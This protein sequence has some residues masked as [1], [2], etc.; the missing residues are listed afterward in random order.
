MK[1][2]VAAMQS[3]YSRQHSGRSDHEALCS[4]SLHPQQLSCADTGTAAGEYDQT[5]AG[6]AAE[7]DIQQASVA[8]SE[9]SALQRQGQSLEQSLALGHPATALAGLSVPEDVDQGARVD[10]DGGTLPNEADPAVLPGPVGDM[11]ESEEL[12]ESLLWFN[13]AEEQVGRGAADRL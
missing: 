8:F 9:Q 12:Q 13:S 7:Q 4:A 2:D 6:S 11:Q 5:G 10:G 1:M 3:S